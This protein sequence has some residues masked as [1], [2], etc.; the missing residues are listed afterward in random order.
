MVLRLRGQRV[1]PAAIAGSAYLAWVV[2]SAF[3]VW[4]VMRR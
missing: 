4:I 2:V 3:V 1:P